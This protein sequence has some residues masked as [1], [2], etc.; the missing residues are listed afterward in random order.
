MSPLTI[1]VLLGSVRRDRVGD[2]A[3]RLV[4]DGLA[5]RGHAPVLVD[6]LEL[7]LPLLDRMYKEYPAGEAPPPL[8]RLAALYRRADASSWSAANINRQ[9]AGAEEPARP[10]PRR[11]RAVSRQ[12]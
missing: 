7:Q 3:A 4:M 12:E 9:P 10:F 2:R 5:A 6:A 8:E 11:R 1:P